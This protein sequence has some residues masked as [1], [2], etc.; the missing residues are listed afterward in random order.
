MKFVFDYLLDCY[1]H[2]VA[3]RKCGEAR[4]VSY[5]NRLFDEIGVSKVPHVV[6]W[7]NNKVIFCRIRSL[8]HSIYQFFRIIVAFILQLPK[9]YSRNKV[10]VHAQ[11]E[12]AVG[13]IL[14]ASRLG[15]SDYD[16]S[17]RRYLK[18][19]L[20]DTEGNDCFFDLNIS[21]RPLFIIEAALSI[22]KLCSNKQF[23]MEG[24]FYVNIFD[25]FYRFLIECYKPATL[26]ALFSAVFNVKVHTLKERL[27][28]FLFY[29]SL[30]G[31]ISNNAMSM[32]VLLTSN[33]LIPEVL[34]WLSLRSSDVK[35]V[36]EILH[37]IPSSNLEEYF[38]FLSGLQRSDGF[39]HHTFIPQIPSLSVA[40]YSAHLDV[41]ERSLAIN[42]YLNNFLNKV[43]YSKEILFLKIYEAISN[44]VQ[45][46]S[47]NKM[48]FTIL[49]VGGMSQ[50]K[51]YL[52]SGEFQ[53]ECKLVAIIS[54]HFSKIGRSFHLLYAPHPGHN[55][56][57]FEGSILQ[58]FKHVSLFRPTMFALFFAEF[59]ISLLSSALYEAAYY[60]IDT[61]LPV[62][63][64]DEIFSEPVL[65]L[66]GNS[67]QESLGTG[68]ADSINLS[69]AKPRRSLG[70]RIWR[71]I[72]TVIIN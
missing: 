7:W 14:A 48:P 3:M 57:L 29:K 6:Y 2:Y 44:L 21:S 60:G 36:V 27:A 4:T 32:L 38:T 43:C 8:V 59:S 53:A 61:F 19:I 20:R 69:L 46:N 51:C 64:S 47:N 15:C 13:V 18:S 58:K 49:F 25:C 72:D 71:V 70:D 39:P 31:V 17:P 23:G 28:L 66:L 40:S 1:Q 67:E 65:G 56:K 35:Q 11:I 30:A 34:R 68:L 26:S 42:T 24:V 52:S 33:S 16:K 12:G 10:I 9:L 54:N 63:I 5:L 37:G 50:N 22:P 45:F 55:K 41:R 62:K